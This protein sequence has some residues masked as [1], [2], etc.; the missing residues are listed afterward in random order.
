MLFKKRI[1]NYNYVNNIQTNGSII[2]LFDSIS[3]NF[4]TN[5]TFYLKFIKL[6]Y[7]N[8]LFL[9]IKNFFFYRSKK[10]NN[11]NLL[12]FQNNYLK[13]NYNYI[14]FEN[15][16]FKNKKLF[17]NREKKKKKKN[18]RE[19]DLKKEVKKKKKF[20]LNISKQCAIYNN[21]FILNILNKFKKKII[22]N[23][24]FNI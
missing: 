13:N 1:I 2:K 14:Y 4:L 7:K 21:V 12:Y 17:F 19:L 9:K 20:F 8:N 18:R 5:T 6:N 24:F 16:M 15:T 10:K 11:L 22:N 23:I 3:S